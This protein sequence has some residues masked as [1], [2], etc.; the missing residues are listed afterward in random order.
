MLCALQARRYEPEHEY[1]SFRD[2]ASST[3][4]SGRKRTVA[5]GGR[6]AAG[7]IQR[8]SS[9]L[10]SSYTS[11]SSVLPTVVVLCTASSMLHR[12]MEG[13][14]CFHRW[15]YVL[16]GDIAQCVYRPMEQRYKHYRDSRS[17]PTFPK[18]LF[19]AVFFN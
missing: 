12:G 7:T 4:P 9:A 13:A 8:R 14:R 1:E 5:A 2:D 3:A 15:R 10:Y 18:I 6:R 16:H 19:F 17:N 11:R